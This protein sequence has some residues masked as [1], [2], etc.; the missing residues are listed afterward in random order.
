VALTAI[1]YPTKRL[2]IRTHQL[3]FDRAVLPV[4]KDPPPW[5]RQRTEGLTGREDNCRNDLPFTV[6]WCAGVVDGNTRR[7][8]MTL[9]TVL[10]VVLVLALIGVI[11]NWPRS[12]AWGYMPSGVVGLLAVVVVVMLATGRI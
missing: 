7:S 11:P 3:L 9:G 1:S 2:A 4:Q 6:A 8:E 10:L 5:V 12:K